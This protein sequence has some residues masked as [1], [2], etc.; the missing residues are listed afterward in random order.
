MKCTKASLAA[1]GLMLLLVLLPGTASARVSFGISIG[2]PFVYHYPGFHHGWYPHHYSYPYYGWYPH[3][4]WHSSSDLGIWIGGYHPIVVGPPVIR[5]N[6]RTGE[7]ATKA[8]EAMP[9]AQTVEQLERLRLRKSELLKV[10]RIGDKERRMQAIRDLAAFSCDDAVRKAMEKV[11]LSDPDPELR[12]QVAA[13]FGKTDNRKVV[14]A[15][16]EAKTTDSSK[17]V[18]RAAYRSIILIKGY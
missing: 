15:L 12:K 10:L 13:S 1:G 4:G 14:A 3:H 17:E 11:L 16:E 18:R 2:T 6:C 8:S 9:D 5:Q 7:V